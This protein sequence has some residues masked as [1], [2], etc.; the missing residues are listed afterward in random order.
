M[1][2]VYG[3]SPHSHSLLSI[4]LLSVCPFPLGP[5]LTSIWSL[6]SHLPIVSCSHS[7]TEFISSSSGC[8]SY[9]LW[10]TVPTLK[11]HH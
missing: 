3:L 5:T 6:A 7:I 11:K 2:L 8:P 4:A 9:G 10:M 1:S